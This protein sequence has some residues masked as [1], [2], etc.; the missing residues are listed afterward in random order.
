MYDSMSTQFSQFSKQFA[1]SAL[2]ANSLLLDHVERVVGVQ[3]KAFESGLQASAAF[4]SEASEVRDFEGAKALAPKGLSLVKDS[5]EQFFSVGQEVFGQSVK[6]GEALVGL[7]KQN[8]EA[9]N[10][11][12]QRTAAT[13]AKAASKTK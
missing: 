11:G 1:D 10:E 6:T 5:T 2:R 9:A 3:M 8:M 12:V 4:A 7:M 13:A